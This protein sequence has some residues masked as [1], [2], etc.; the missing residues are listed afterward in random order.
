MIEKKIHILETH[1]SLQILASLSHFLPC[2]L[3][4]I[5]LIYTL[6]SLPSLFLSPLRETR[7]APQFS[8][9]PSPPTHTPPPS[10]SQTPPSGLLSLLIFYSLSMFLLTPLHPTLFLF[11]LPHCISHPPPLRPYSLTHS[12]TPPPPLPHPILFP[13]L[14]S[15]HSYLFNIH[16]LL[17]TI[18]PTHFPSVASYQPTPP[19]TLAPALPHTEI[20]L[21]LPHPNPLTTHQSASGYTF[22]LSSIAPSLHPMPPPPP[23]LCFQNPTVSYFKAPHPPLTMFPTPLHLPNSITS[24]LFLQAHYLPS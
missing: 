18:A 19:L 6:S 10:L 22:D 14:P 17:T 11:T 7:S 13:R 20:F 3:S 4:C 2:F 9:P 24:F 8:L 15:V 21:T 1:F 5:P 12:L 16:P 23:S